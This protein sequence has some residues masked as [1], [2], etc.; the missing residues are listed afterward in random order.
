MNGSAAVE[1]VVLCA[2]D[3]AF[4]GVAPK[5]DVHH[6]E[7]PLHLAFS[8]YVFDPAGRT[9]MTRRAHGKPTFPGVRTNTCC[10]HPGPGESLRAAVTRRLR[11]ELGLQ[12]DA[13]DL[14]LPAFRYRATAADGTAENE[15]CPVYRAT[16]M[17]PAVVVDPEEVDDAWW[18]SWPDFAAE[19]A[20]A[21]PLSPWSTAQVVELTALGSDPHAWPV[22]DPALLPAAARP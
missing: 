19:T 3:G 15:L 1:Q 4:A 20:G 13:V 8:C 6:A 2:E 5:C 9:L 10:G 12:A 11:Q 16:V 22:A 7:T 17:S 21:D 18:L 14:V